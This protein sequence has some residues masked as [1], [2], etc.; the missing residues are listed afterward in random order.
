MFP[1]LPTWQTRGQ[2]KSSSEH[3]KGFPTTSSWFLWE[4]PIH[5]PRPHEAVTG[6]LNSQLVFTNVLHG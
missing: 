3:G 6:A 2:P 4:R 5:R 1:S